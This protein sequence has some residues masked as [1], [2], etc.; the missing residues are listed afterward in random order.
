MKIDFHVHTNR[1]VD[2]VHTPREMLKKAKAAGLDGI[3][4]TDHNRLFPWIEARRLSKEFSIVVIPGIE[5]GNIGIQKHWIALGIT[6]NIADFRLSIQKVLSHIRSES[7]ISVAPHPHTRLGYAE[8]APAGF[9]A[10][11]VL[12]GCEPHA[13]RLINNTHNIPELG[14]SDAHAAPMLGFTWTD[15]DA[16]GTAED[17]LEAVRHGRC[18]PGGSTIPFFPHLRFY[19]LYVRHRIIMQ[20]AEACR[21]FRRVLRDIR[22]VRDFEHRRTVV[23]HHELQGDQISSFSIAAQPLD[24]H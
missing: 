19:P 9:D 20:P 4:I 6:R 3:A 8:Y 11:E 22:K 21:T 17:I 1:S 5:G 7:G 16:E 24:W 10:V 12:N 18:S 23:E 14:G 13:N 15:V 2:A